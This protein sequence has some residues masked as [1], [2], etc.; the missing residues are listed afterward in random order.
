MT[1]T[2]SAPDAG[3]EITHIQR[4]DASRDNAT[5]L[6]QDLETIDARIRQIEVQMGA[7]P[8]EEETLR[9]RREQLL[10]RKEEL[11]GMLCG[12][13]GAALRSEAA[14][15]QEHADQVKPALDAAIAEHEQASAAF[16][17]ATAAL[18][19]A[20]ARLSEAERQHVLLEREHG[21]RS[22]EALEV[23]IDATRAEQGLGLFKPERFRG[24]VAWSA[25]LAP[26]TSN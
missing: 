3:D 13:R 11:P 26:V 4:R 14:R 25:V 6:R 23:G 12:A 16:A 5:R 21:I 9:A 18:E 17:E 20:R 8:G 24:D 7:E 2:T 15:L 10:R 19:S 22:R 1:E